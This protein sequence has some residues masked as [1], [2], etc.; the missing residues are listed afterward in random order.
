MKRLAVIPARWGS[1]RF[2]GKP[3]A[4]LLG[5]PMVQHVYERCREAECF[6]EIVVA[7]DDARIEAAVKSFGAAVQMTSPSCPS[8]TDRVAEVARARDAELIVNV[9][10]D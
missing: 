7:T 1:T 10:A 2:P 8:G 9:Q 4:M 6:D 5:K 3:L